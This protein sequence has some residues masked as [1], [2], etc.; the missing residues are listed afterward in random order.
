MQRAWMVWFHL[1]YMPIDGFRLGQIPGLVVFHTCLK[2]L[3][4][5]SGR[6]VRARACC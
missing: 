6:W 4:N 3:Q 1:E 5:G 2:I